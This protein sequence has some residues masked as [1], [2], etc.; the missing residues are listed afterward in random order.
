MYAP[1]APGPAP[2]FIVIPKFVEIVAKSFAFTFLRTREEGRTASTTDVRTKNITAIFLGFRA[3]A[4]IARNKID[5]STNLGCT[6]DERDNKPAA[7]IDLQVINFLSLLKYSLINRATA[8]MKTAADI[9]SYPIV[10]VLKE[11]VGL[12]AIIKAIGNANFFR[13]VFEICFTKYQLE[14]A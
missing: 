1:V 6:K 11:R 3:N 14:K 4:Q 10:R 8:R 5:A 2:K 7:D 12:N 9:D 13:V